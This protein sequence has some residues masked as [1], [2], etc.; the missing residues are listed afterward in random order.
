MKKILPVLALGIFLT[1]NILAQKRILVDFRVDRTSAPAKIPLPKQKTILSKVFLRYLADANKCNSKLETGAVGDFLEAA[2]KAGQIVPSITDTVQ[3]S[4]TAAGQTQTAYIISVSEC[5][6]SHADNFGSQRI[7]IFSGQ[8]LVTDLDLDFRSNVLKKTDLNADGINELLMSSG[9]MNQG[10]M[11][12]SAALLGFKDGK[13]NVI[14]DFGQV[15]EDSC[16]SGLPDSDK[17]A[18]VISAGTGAPG[19]MPKLQLDNYKSTCRTPSRW[20][21]VSAGKVTNR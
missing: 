11:V 6:A 16:A 13:L 15:S 19:T 7:A 20:R 18:S 5:F 1:P 17:T 2:R 8:K 14:E 10:V 21:F 12:E 4:F 3:G 9:Y